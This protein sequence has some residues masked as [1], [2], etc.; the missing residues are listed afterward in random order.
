MR[1]FKGWPNLDTPTACC[2]H[3]DLADFRDKQVKTE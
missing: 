2:S 1:L 3:L